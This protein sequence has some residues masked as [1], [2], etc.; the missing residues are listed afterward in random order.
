MHIKPGVERHIKISKGIMPRYCMVPG[1]PERAA[2]IA[3]RFDNCKEVIRSREYLGFIGE[4]DGIPMAVCSTGMGGASTSILVEELANV[5]VD[6][7]IRIGSAGARQIHIAPGSVVIFTAVHREDGTSLA[8]L[9]AGYPAVADLQVV[10]ALIEAGREVREEIFYGI[11]SSRD[12]F[13]VK[14]EQLVALLTERGHIVAAEQEASTLF[15]V[16]S[17]RQVRS[18]CVV[19]T[20][21]NILRERLEPEKLNPLF[22]KAQSDAITTA[23]KAIQKIAKDDKVYYIP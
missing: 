8:Y 16:A 21:S 4:I 22:A 18:G 12:A 9:P 6:C 23:I 15:I 10:N 14:D 13:Y 5:G 20:D 7:F 3:E 2:L 1:S 19:A 11:G 17:T